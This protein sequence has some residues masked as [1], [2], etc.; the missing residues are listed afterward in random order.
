MTTSQQIS[1]FRV[2]V[3]IVSSVSV[4][5]IVSDVIRH[6]VAIESTADAVKVWTGSLIVGSMIADQASTHVNNQLD[7]GI[8][9]LEHRKD[10][11]RNERPAN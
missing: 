10:E 5:K 4:W 9:W 7:K 1:L 11:A 6:N 8:A 2:G 3:N